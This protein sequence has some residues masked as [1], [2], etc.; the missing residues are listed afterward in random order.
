LDP[1]TNFIVFW[2]VVLARLILP[3]FIPRF[4]LP[5]MIAC[6]V[7]DGVDQ[8]IF[9]KYTTINLD[10][11]QGYDKSLDIYYL[12]L[13]YVATMRNWSN[14]AG[15]RVSRF[16]YHYRL[17]GVVAFE[18]TQVRALLLI[19]PNT[20]EYFFDFYEGVR[21]RWDPRRMSKKLVVGAAAFIWI[22][23]KLPQEWWIHI[24]QLDVT[25]FVKET[26]YGV[27]T[28]ATL[29]EMIAA[30]PMLTL[31]IVAAV[32]GLVVLAW[33]VV[34]RKLPPAE[35]RLRLAADPLPA[36]ITER[37]ERLNKLAHAR[38][39]S[40]AL[41]EKVVIVSLVSVIF[42]QVLPNVKAT[43]LQLA[44][45]VAV[46]IAVN[47]LLS[48]YLAARG[49]GWESVLREFAVMLVANVGIVW[50]YV[51]LAPRLQGQVD[52]SNALFFV[53]LLT[54]IVTLYDRYRPIF[55][56]RFADV[57]GVAS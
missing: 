56:A 23:I 10:G 11:Y 50:A 37:A 29:S 47:A 38:F 46:V 4:P 18:L 33:W 16:L 15:F 22:F 32:V 21:A 1:S 19:F 54:L 2:T 24:A 14:L 26:I 34:T 27:P 41:L 7:V 25:D 53:L 39:W 20:F 5:A 45:A 31:F 12:T 30:E 44:V 17:V 57:E 9:Q 52:R 51:L 13:G 36:G 43:I 49:V 40:T 42:A 55:E 6:L 48:H 28:T 8:S 35:Y 3:L